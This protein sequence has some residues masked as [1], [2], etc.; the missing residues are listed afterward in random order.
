MKEKYINQ[1]FPKWFEH[2][3]TIIAHGTQREDCLPTL[4]ESAIKEHNRTV[5]KLVEVTMLLFKLSP[6]EAEDYWYKDLTD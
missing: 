3:G 2:G 5:D 6:E 1:K 4:P